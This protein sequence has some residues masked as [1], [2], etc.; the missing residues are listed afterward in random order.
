MG[1][2]GIVDSGTSNTISQQEIFV[3]DG[4]AIFE[5]YN[6]TLLVDL[7]P[8]VVHLRIDRRRIDPSFVAGTRG[9]NASAQ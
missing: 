8:S 7:A 3:W 1:K 5:P 4:G 9:R 6:R 2:D